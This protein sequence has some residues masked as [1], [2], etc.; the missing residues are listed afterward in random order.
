[1]NT[2]AVS[3]SRYDLMMRTIH[4]TTL[5]LIAGAFTAVWIADPAVDP[6]AYSPAGRPGSPLAPD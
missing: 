5:A 6:E 4:W 2:Q 3:P 1:M